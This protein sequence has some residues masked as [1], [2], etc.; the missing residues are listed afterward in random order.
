MQNDWLVVVVPAIAWPRRDSSSAPLFYVL[1]WL[2]NVHHFPPSP[3]HVHTLVGDGLVQWEEL[4]AFCVDTGSAAQ[5]YAR[6]ERA[7]HFGPVREYPGDFATKGAIT[8]LQVWQHP[9]NC[10]AVIEEKCP[11]LRLY[12]PETLR[13]AAELHAIPRP[14]QEDISAIP[15]SERKQQASST[16]HNH[17]N[18]E[19]AS[20]STI[21]GSIRS[22]DTAASASAAQQAPRYSDAFLGQAI[23]DTLLGHPL[24]TVDM[25]ANDLCAAPGTGTDADQKASRQGQDA[26]DKGHAARTRV[27]HAELANQEKNGIPRCTVT[28][29][30]FCPEIGMVCLGQSDGSIAVYKSHGLD[31]YRGLCL[32]SNNSKTISGITGKGQF[33]GVNGLSSPTAFDNSASRPESAS[34]GHGRA[35][36]HVPA[37]TLSYPTGSATS[38]AIRRSL[39]YLMPHLRAAV[40]KAGILQMSSSTAE[41]LA[42]LNT[43]V[44]SGF[45]SPDGAASPAPF[46]KLS[47]AASRPFGKHGTSTAASSAVSTPTVANNSQGPPNS[48]TSTIAGGSTRMRGLL[49]VNMIPAHVFRTCG[50]E[51]LM[52]AA[53]FALLPVGRMEATSR[54]ATSHRLAALTASPIAHMAWCGSVL[55]TSCAGDATGTVSVWDPVVMRMLCKFKLHAGAIMDL[56]SITPAAASDSS[57]TSGTGINASHADAHRHHQHRHHQHPMFASTSLDGTLC[58]V[59]AKRWRRAVVDGAVI[60]EDSHSHHMQAEAS[61]M[62]AA[63]GV[64]NGAKEKRK[65]KARPQTASSMIS[66]IGVSMGDQGDAEPEDDQGDKEI[67]ASSK[68]DVSAAIEVAADGQARQNSTTASTPSLQHDATAPTDSCRSSISGG[69]PPRHDRC[70]SGP[71]MHHKPQR[72]KP[73]ET[74][75]VDDAGYRVR[76]RMQEL[77]AP[78]RRLHFIP[79]SAPAGAPAS[80]SSSTTSSDVSRSNG[81]AAASGLILA[82]GFDPIAIIIDP[83]T[84]TIISRLRGHRDC[85]LSI[86]STVLDG[87]LR[88]VT[89]DTGGCVK[90]WTLPGMTAGGGSDTTASSGAGGGSSD[91]SA[92]LGFGRQ[93]ASFEV[94]SKSRYSRFGDSGNG[95]HGNFAAA[96]IK[97]QHLSDAN[98]RNA[99]QSMCCIPATGLIIVGSHKMQPY[100]SQPDDDDDDNS[101]GNGGRESAAAT[102]SRLLSGYGAAASSARSQ[103]VGSAAVTGEGGAAAA[104]LMSQLQAPI[105]EPGSGLSVAG[106]AFTSASN[107]FVIAQGRNIL[108]FDCRGNHRFTCYNVLP[109]PATCMVPA[110]IQSARR[111]GVN[112]STS[113]GGLAALAADT[114]RKLVVGCQDGSIA[115]INAGSGAVIKVAPIASKHTADVT[116]VAC[117]PSQNHIWSVGWDRSIRLHSGDIAGGSM[118]LHHLR[119]VEGAH[120][121]DI[122][123]IVVSAPS[124]VA[125]PGPA[126]AENSQQQHRSTANGL[127]L[128]ATTAAD[129]VLRVWDY[130]TLRPDGEMR[131]WSG[132]PTVMC[133]VPGYPLLV[134]GD[135]RGYASVIGV[136]PAPRHLRHKHIAT[137]RVGPAGVSCLQALQ[138][139]S[140]INPAAG[141]AAS[142]PPTS[143]NVLMLAAGCEDGTVTILPLQRI[144]DICN[145]P[146]TKECPRDDG[147]TDTSKT[148]AESIVSRAPMLIGSPNGGARRSRAGSRPRSKPG[149]TGSAAGH[150]TDTQTS[151]SR[152]TRSASQRTASAARVR[153]LSPAAEMLPHSPMRAA[154]AATAAPAIDQDAKFQIVRGISGDGHGGGGGHHQYQ[155]LGTGRA[156]PTPAF[157]SSRVAQSM[158]LMQ[159]LKDKRAVL[160]MVRDSATGQVTSRSATGRRS[161]ANAGLGYANSA[162]LG[163][164][165]AQP[166]AAATTSRRASLPSLRPSLD[167]AMHPSFQSPTAALRAHKATGILS[168]ERGASPLTSPNR[169]SRFG[170]LKLAQLHGGRAASDGAAV[171]APGD[172]D[173]H[174]RSSKNDAVAMMEGSRPG[175]AAAAGADRSSSSASTSRSSVSAAGATFS[176]AA[177]LVGRVGVLT[178]T[179]IAL[180]A[181]ITHMCPMLASWQAHPSPIRSLQLLPREA[182]SKSQKSSTSSASNSSSS[183]TNSMAILSAGEGGDVRIWSLEGDPL[184]LIAN[185]GVDVGWILTELKRGTT[186]GLGGRPTAGSPRPRTSTTGGMNR[187]SSGAVNGR[188][189]VAVGGNAGEAHGIQ[190]RYCP[191]ETAEDTHLADAAERML[192][193]VKA[194]AA[195]AEASAFKKRQIARSMA[196]ISRAVQQRVNS[197]AKGASDHNSAPM[198]RASMSTLS[199]PQL[200]SSFNDDAQRPSREQQLTAKAAQARNALSRVMGLSSPHPLHQANNSTESSSLSNGGSA[201]LMSTKGKRPP[202]LRNT[203]TD[204]SSHP[205][206][207]SPLPVVTALLAGSKKMDLAFGARSPLATGKR[208]ARSG[209]QAADDSVSVSGMSSSPAPS[210]L[211]SPIGSSGSRR[212]SL[213]VPVAGEDQLHHLARSPSPGKPSGGQRSIRGSQFLRSPSRTSQQADSTARMPAKQKKRNSVFFAEG[214]DGDELVKTGTQKSG[215]A[216]EKQHI[217]AAKDLIAALSAAS[218]TDAGGNSNSMITRLNGRTYASYSSLALIKQ[219]G[220]AGLPPRPGAGL[221]GTMNT[222]ELRRSFAS[223]SYV[224]GPNPQS[225]LSRNPGNRANSIAAVLD[226]EAYALQ[227]RAAVALLAELADSHANMQ[228]DELA[229]GGSETEEHRVNAAASGARPQESR[230]QRSQHDVRDEYDQDLQREAVALART[231][232]L[233]ARKQKVHGI[234][235]MTSSTRTKGSDH[236]QRSEPNA[237]AADRF[238]KLSDAFIDGNETDSDEELIAGIMQTYSGSRRRSGSTIAASEPSASVAMTPDAGVPTTSSRQKKQPEKQVFTVSTKAVLE[239][240]SSEAKSAALL[241]AHLAMTGQQPLR[242]KYSHLMSESARRTGPRSSADF[243]DSHADH[244]LAQHHLTLSTPSASPQSS[245]SVSSLT[246]PGIASGANSRRS[247]MAS[248]VTTTRRTASTLESKRASTGAEDAEQAKMRKEIERLE[249]HALSMTQTRSRGTSATFRAGQ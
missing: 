237:S 232:H 154:T 18:H 210:P 8:S 102:G 35:H 95:S 26:E 170:R 103:G 206:L 230:Q 165:S 201:L 137:F 40:A 162:V 83:S 168:P 175:T 17:N 207:A 160:S 89:M 153:G 67:G 120:T 152:R 43:D 76:R 47:C 212:L 136:R 179:K 98:D 209:I 12:E 80:S 81:S 178:N 54:D 169:L 219:R 194:A 37:A 6:P 58:L 226:D 75:A 115:E 205:M 235:T 90:V 249:R 33:S 145:V 13:I 164:S 184:G 167:V 107:T 231:A 161:S 131:R 29:A 70:S 106:A 224:P 243:A 138:L 63:L 113:A 104:V 105:H 91:R 56:V 85:L 124:E 87:C 234:A 193:K 34:S 192:R 19:R 204:A 21:E 183:T 199:L 96:R 36:T 158:A 41:K 82:A 228:E 65:G 218:G 68:N 69:L 114:F 22:A 123:C 28:S 71:T 203:S 229:E 46:R 135:A 109:A 129:C 3:P 236:G 242:E 149:R 92:A 39:V 221:A 233:R 216:L 60:T 57:S 97:S 74:L 25:D 16:N 42:A 99:P 64:Q 156:P 191:P 244:L 198:P 214:D 30:C 150:D 117:V 248:C 146:P 101:R 195:A 217:D 246:T 185:P 189:N 177:H 174:Q 182:A 143:V 23:V 38:A 142:N 200:P 50:Q 139:A 45:L 187:P 159:S 20:A 118:T 127:G 140:A 108:S 52:K 11:M 225:E 94:Y 133:F 125:N 130:S 88:G 49:P 44:Q 72:D 188:G 14:Q 61:G 223:L 180:G 32:S 155:P 186:S 132:E 55:L 166:A 31:V 147:P 84:G 10:V 110:T 238:A 4:L 211:P 51:A 241:T 86:S 215:S 53:T 148:A 222:Q 27:L 171:D 116:C 78:M 48:I 239:C 77:P 173:H 202:T 111:S 128:V 213:G 227:R 196:Q 79:A 208:Q 121:A 7:P 141:S 73:A 122:N 59:E 240:M 247:S 119:G 1:R 93:V 112:N 62:Q 197:V 126:G 134:V 181:D 190:W 5:R 151:Q 9:L 24:K 163:G 144:L 172:H 2:T 245:A 66:L 176:R 220:A 100:A 157:Q 15:D